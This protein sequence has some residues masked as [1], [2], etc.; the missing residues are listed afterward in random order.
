MAPQNRSNADEKERKEGKEGVVSKEKKGS[1]LEFSCV[2]DQSSASIHHVHHFAALDLCRSGEFRAPECAS[3]F[4]KRNFDAECEHGV[5]GRTRAG[6]AVH[7]EGVF[8]GGDLKDALD[9]LDWFDRGEI[10]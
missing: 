8:V 7:H 5:G 10:G 9:K 4:P 2:K 6:E 3:S 1:F